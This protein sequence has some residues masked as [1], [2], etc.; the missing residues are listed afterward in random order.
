MAWTVTGTLDSAWTMSDEIRRWRFKINCSVKTTDASGDN[1]LSD[2][3]VASTSMTS[4]YADMVIEDIKGGKVVAVEYIPGTNPPSDA[5]NVTLDNEDGTVIFNSTVTAAGTAEVLGNAV[6]SDTGHP[7]RF[8]APLPAEDLIFACSQ[9]CSSE[10]A[11]AVTA[12]F[13]IWVE[14]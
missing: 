11:T 2:L 12:D 7:D 1:T 6:V 8:G 10:Y 5:G 13:Y 3:L 9:F 4:A 14:K